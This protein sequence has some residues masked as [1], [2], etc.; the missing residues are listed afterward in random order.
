MAIGLQ[1]ITLM[2]LAVVA[3]GPS[4]GL[5]L[6]SAELREQGTSR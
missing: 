2:V 4:R 6:P 5:T 3:C 1:L